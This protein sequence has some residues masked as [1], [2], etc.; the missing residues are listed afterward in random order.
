M[1]LATL[2]HRETQSHRLKS[3]KPP[4]NAT[5]RKVFPFDG[6][7]PPNNAAKIFC[8]SSDDEAFLVTPQIVRAKLTTMIAKNISGAHPH[9]LIV[10]PLVS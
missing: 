10:F 9:L 1:P 2:A 3:I 6:G 7:H 4:K 8:F 5:K